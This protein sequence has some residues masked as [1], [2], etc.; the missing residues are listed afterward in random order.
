MHQILHLIWLDSIVSLCWLV[1]TLTLCVIY[2]IKHNQR[3]VL[4]VAYS[5]VHCCPPSDG[6]VI[7]A[8]G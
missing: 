7:C 8:E 1:S 4:L 2:R 5:I 6:K 3:N